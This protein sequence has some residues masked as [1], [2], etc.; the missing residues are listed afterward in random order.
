MHPRIYCHKAPALLFLDEP[1]SGL[2]YVSAR[3]VVAVLAR[4]GRFPPVLQPLGPPLTIF[5]HL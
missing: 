3:D 2:D 4:C 1:T 5:D